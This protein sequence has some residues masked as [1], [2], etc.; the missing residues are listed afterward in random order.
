MYE[1]CRVVQAFNP[2]FA[3]TFLDPAFIDSMQAIT[4]LAGLGMLSDLK[5]EL[6]P[7][8][9]AAA[10]A[11]DFDKADV[12]EFTEAVLRWWRTN[13]NS[14]PTW[15]KAVRIVFAFSPNSAACER[16][17]SLL[18]RM[19]GEEQLSALADYIRA[20]LM[21]RFNERYVG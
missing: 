2:N 7:Y 17:F 13:G 15:A 5:K 16:V 11:P 6:P 18:K 19:F 9:A 14:F 3:A 4:P 21:V 1:I 20:A 12:A 10:H 8:V